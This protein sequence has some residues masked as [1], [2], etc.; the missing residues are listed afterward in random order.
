MSEPQEQWRRG[1]AI[2]TVCPQCEIRRLYGRG[3][4]CLACRMDDRDQANQERRRRFEVA[5]TNL[6]RRIN[7]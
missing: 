5:V 3:P 1:T 2:V 7:G 4:V 6:Q